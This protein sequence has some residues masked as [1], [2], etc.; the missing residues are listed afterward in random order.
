LQHDRSWQKMTTKA[1]RLYLQEG[2][3]KQEFA[4]CV[5]TVL[6][7]GPDKIDAPDDYRTLEL[8][9]ARGRTRLAASRL[10]S[11]K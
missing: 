6:R 11:T 8:G 7:T 10:N 2:Q 4:A 5:G 3:P 9:K 1:A